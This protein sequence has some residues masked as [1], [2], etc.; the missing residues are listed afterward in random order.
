MSSID[1]AASLEL[2]GGDRILVG[3]VAVIA[4]VALAVG[5][6]LR[7]EVLAAGEGTAKMQEIGRAVQEGAAAYLNR[8]FRTL[9]VFVVIVFVLLF[10]LP[11]DG[12]GEQIGR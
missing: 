10:F 12:L 9:S 4:L 2:G 11:A 5:F 6:V 1:L 7:R 3:I 8:Q